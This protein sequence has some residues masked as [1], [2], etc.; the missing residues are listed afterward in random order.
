MAEE[1]WRGSMRKEEFENFLN[2]QVKLE[3]KIVRLVRG[4]TENVKNLLI[5][6]LLQSIGLDSQKHADMLRSITAFLK[7]ETPFISEEERQRIPIL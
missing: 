1:N 3:E 5:K 2:N 4:V 6:I 7:H